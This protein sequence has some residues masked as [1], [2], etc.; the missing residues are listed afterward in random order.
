MGAMDLVAALR[1]KPFEPFRIVSLQP[2]E[3]V[4]PA[5]VGRLGDLQLAAD[6]GDVLALTQHP[7]SLREFAYH[8]LRRVPLPRCH[9]DIEPSCPPRGRQ[10][11]HSTW[12]NQP[13]S[14]QRQ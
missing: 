10:D 5:V 3:L 2:A 11:S 6:V 9:V 14:R 7:I 4:A 8:L 12:T 1:R 13:G